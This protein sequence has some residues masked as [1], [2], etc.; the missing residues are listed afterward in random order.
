MLIILCYSVGTFCL[1]DSSRKILEA[2]SKWEDKISFTAE[3]SNSRTSG[4]ALSHAH[5]SRQEKARVLRPG[6]QR[7]T[8][9]AECLGWERTLPP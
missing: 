5:G 4:T 8:P 3:L 6:T 9:A 7:P 1:F 2:F